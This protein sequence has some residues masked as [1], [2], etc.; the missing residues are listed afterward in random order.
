MESHLNSATP[1]ITL[2]N[3]NYT[4]LKKTSQEKMFPKEVGKSLRVPLAQAASLP[5]ASM[6]QKVFADDQTC[7]WCEYLVDGN[8]PFAFLPLTYI[9]R[10]RSNS[11]K[12][13]FASRPFCSVKAD[14]V[15]QE[16]PAS[17]LAAG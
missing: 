2:E 1:D 14:T 3:L 11:T 6:T 4:G 16:S 9:L 12:D 7:S 8:F 13:P 15:T 10:Q 5:A 17:A